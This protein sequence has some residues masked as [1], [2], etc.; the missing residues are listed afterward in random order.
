M[1]EPKY[2]KFKL[3]NGLKVLLIPMKNIKLV[4]INAVP[5]SASINT[6]L[7]PSN[8]I[9]S[10]VDIKENEEV[11]TSSFFPT[12]SAINDINKASV[13]LETANEYFV[14]TYFLRVFSSF[15]TSGPKIY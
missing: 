10:I 2:T 6:G 15:K 4:S 9:T 11:I 14:F 8:V 5:T 1:M 3:S 12:S 7:A 13:P